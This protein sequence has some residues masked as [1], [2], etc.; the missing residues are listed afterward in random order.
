MLY[1]HKDMTQD[2]IDFLTMIDQRAALAMLNNAIN[3]LEYNY[4]TNSE[5]TRQYD[6]NDTSNAIDLI[7][8]NVMD[9]EDT[10]GG[11]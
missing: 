4:Y 5:G 7:I 6:G 3:H 2:D 11:D 9:M 1:Y 10:K 8:Y